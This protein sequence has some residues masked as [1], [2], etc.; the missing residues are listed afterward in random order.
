MPETGPGNLPKFKMD[1]ETVP[2]GVDPELAARR[3]TLIEAWRAGEATPE[4]T[5][6]E[7]MALYWD[8]QKTTNEAT[9][10]F[11]MQSSYAFPAEASVPMKV[12]DAIY[13]E[14]MEGH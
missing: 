13:N 8:T 14:S 10:S 4:D 2:E 11:L 12:A 1:T 5:M 9:N 6:R 7:L 3:T